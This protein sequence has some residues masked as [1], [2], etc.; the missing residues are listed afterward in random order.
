M[1]S[2]SVLSPSSMLANNYPLQTILN[3]NLSEGEQRRVVAQEFEAM[4]INEILKQ[5]DATVDYEEN[6]VYGG[7]A[8]DIYRNLFNQELSRSLAAG[9]GIGLSDMI[10]EEMEKKGHE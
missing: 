3:S 10:V 4:F 9:G 1:E 5:M 8:E 7:K 2:A 6:L